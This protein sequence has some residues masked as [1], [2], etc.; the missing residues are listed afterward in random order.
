MKRQLIIQKDIVKKYGDPETNEIV[1]DVISKGSVLEWSNFNDFKNTENH[2]KVN[3]KDVNYRQLEGI[4]E[5]LAQIPNELMMEIAK[6]FQN[7]ETTEEIKRDDG[8][9]EIR[10]IRKEL[11][12]LEVLEKTILFLENLYPKK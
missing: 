9:T 12:P 2:I 7:L 5:Y 4:L 10:T 3:G 1:E 6:I 11:N 8:K